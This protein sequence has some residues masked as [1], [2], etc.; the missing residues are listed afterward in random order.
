MYNLREAY[1]HGE[2]R[3]VKPKSLTE[4]DSDFEIPNLGK[5]F[6]TQIEEDWGTK[7]TGLVLGYNLKI[8]IDE[9]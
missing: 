2:C 4:V 5:I 7:I 1:I 9:V 8:L 3:S 6:W